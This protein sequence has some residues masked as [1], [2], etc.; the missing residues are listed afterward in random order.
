MATATDSQQ[1]GAVNRDYQSQILTRY[2]PLLRIESVQ[3]WT[4]EG[5]ADAWF[6]KAERRLRALSVP[7]SSWKFVLTYFIEDEALDAWL[8]VEKADETYAS[9]RNDFMLTTFPKQMEY[10]RLR[11][12]LS[13]AAELE[14]M[15]Q[16]FKFI[17][18]LK[19]KMSRILSRNPIIVGPSESELKEAVYKRIPRRFRP[20]L[21]RPVYDVGI[22]YAEFKTLA[23]G[24]ALADEMDAEVKVV[25]AVKR[26]RADAQIPTENTE[27]ETRFQP[28]REESAP[29]D[30]C[31]RTGHQKGQCIVHKNGWTCH[32]CGKKGH[33]KAVCRST[34][35]GLSVMVSPHAESKEAYLMTQIQELQKQLQM[36]QVKPRKTPQRNTRKPDKRDM[37]ESEDE[38][39]IDMDTEVNAIPIQGRATLKAVVPCLVG[40]APT[41]AELDHRRPTRPN[42]SAPHRGYRNTISDMHVSSTPIHSDPVTP[43]S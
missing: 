30:S 4:T 5:A 32:A 11:R 15:E 37:D 9:R 23:L 40:T 7:L 12:E 10:G 36:L 42:K 6:E 14:S 16:S 8:S 3:D 13:S 25:Q 17:D 21:Q 33:V 28:R 2:L 43:H 38:A 39:V 34:K 18:E 35:Q 22:G 26:T 41:L 31:G 1:N 24:D 29:C 19:R 27:K 20:Q